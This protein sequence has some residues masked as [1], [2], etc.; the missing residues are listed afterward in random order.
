MKIHIG[1]KLL[2]KIES[3]LIFLNFLKIAILTDDNIP[4]QFIDEV[5][6]H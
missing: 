2:S 1:K 6:N 5:E 3:C 4:K